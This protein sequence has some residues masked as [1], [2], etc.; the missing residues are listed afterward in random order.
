MIRWLWVRATK[1]SER[2]RIAVAARSTCPPSRDR[3]RVDCRCD[4]CDEQGIEDVRTDDTANRKGDVVAPDSGE[5]GHQFGKASANCDQCEPH[6]DLGN[7]HGPRSADT[8]PDHEF[9]PVDQAHEANHDQQE[10]REDSAGVFRLTEHPLPRW[11]RCH[12]GSLPLAFA[13]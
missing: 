4:A 9:C 3:H 8:P 10:V 5:R 7:T 1:K 11:A 6:D 2:D 12:D 13:R